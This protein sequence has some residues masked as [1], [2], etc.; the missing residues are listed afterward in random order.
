MIAGLVVSDERR[1]G[2]D[3]DLFVHWID[4]DGDGCDTRRE[5][6]IIES[7]T[8]VTVSGRCRLS[9][10]SWISPFDGVATNDPADLDIDHLVPLAEAWDSG[11]HA[12]T[13]AQ[14]RDYA[15]DLD[16]A[17]ALVA[18]TDNLNQ[19]KSDR[20]PAEWLPPLTAYRCTY[21]RDWISVKKKWNL[22]VDSDEANALRRVLASC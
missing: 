22:S 5:V 18:V 11:A 10:G 8:T 12:W 4:A 19:Q 17:S 14:R 3:R 21:V 16:L 1:A 2:Y 7:L 13:P 20:D 9:G 6:L 15:N